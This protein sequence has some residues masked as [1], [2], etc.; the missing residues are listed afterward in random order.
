MCRKYS[1]A[2]ADYPSPWSVGLLLQAKIFLFVAACPII[3]IF[4]LPEE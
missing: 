3:N 2:P 4:I 1:T